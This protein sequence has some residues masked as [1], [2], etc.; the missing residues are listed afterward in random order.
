MRL[1][2]WFRA[3]RKMYTRCF[4]RVGVDFFGAC[5]PHAFG[6][7]GVCCSP[8]GRRHRRHRGHVVGRLNVHP[9]SRPFHASVGQNSF[10]HCHRNNRPTPDDSIHRRHAGSDVE[11]TVVIV[12]LV[13]VTCTLCI[14]SS[15]CLTLWF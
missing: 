7:I 12:I 1:A 2:V 4:R 15:S 5:G 3:L 13:M 14:D 8:S 9:R 6:R 10:H 11:I